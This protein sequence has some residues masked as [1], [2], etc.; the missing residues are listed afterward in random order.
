MKRWLWI[1]L[2][3]VV[4]LTPAYSAQIAKSE[5]MEEAETEKLAGWKWANFAL[6]VAGLGYF[7]VKKAPAFFNARTEEIQK[8]IKDATGLKMDAD[9]RSS[10][11]DKRMATLAE[12]VQKLRAVA[13][14]DMEHEG[15]RIEAETRATLQRIH[16][17]TL[18]EIESLNQQAALA[19]RE[20]AVRLATELAVT[21]LR[22]RPDQIDQNEL[23]RGFSEDVLKERQVA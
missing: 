7:F 22:E 11:I 10:E 23:I 4:T 19:V 5:R 1:G 3:V 17:H 15:Q 14:A 13:R 12:E 16:E 18:R 9:F 21:E 8:A 2:F 6:L 20:H